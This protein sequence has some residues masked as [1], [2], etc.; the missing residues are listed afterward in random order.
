MIAFGGYLRSKQYLVGIDETANALMSIN[1]I[2]IGNF[3]QLI[4][5]M[6]IC[7]ARSKDQWKDVL[8]HYQDFAKEYQKGLNTKVVDESEIPKR[9]PPAQVKRYQLEDIKKWLYNRK[10]KDTI[11]T[12]FYSPYNS[13][14]VAFFRLEEEDLVELGFWIRKMLQKLAVDRRRKKEKNKVRGDLDLR[15]LLRSRFLKGDELV[16]LYF[17][18][19]KKQKSKMVF[20]C[21]VS[22]SMDL[23]SHFITALVHRLPK[24][25]DYSAIYYFNTELYEV[26]DQE[27]IQE[28]AGLWAGGTRIGHCFSQWL[29]HLPAWFDKKTKILIYSD[30]WDTGDLELLNESMYAMQKMSHK[31]IW[32]NPVITK[33]QDFEVAGMS[34]AKEHVDILA[35]V[36]NLRTLKD[37]IRGL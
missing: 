32:L 19:P 10:D 28:V 26:Q 36:Y 37:F 35:T 14:E 7:F 25:F 27:D 15:Q 33:V 34:I 5:M 1:Y 9:N 8:T 29:N 6:Q 30:G 20:L 12:P 3:D 2:D 24:I 11:E 17:R 18:Y 13:D 23:Y 16:Q 22:K 21:D 31:I 4:Q